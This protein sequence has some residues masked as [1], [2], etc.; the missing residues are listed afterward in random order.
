V[1]LKKHPSIAALEHQGVDPLHR[2]AALAP[3]LT[4]VKTSTVDQK[5][6]N[7]TQ[8]M[9][10][11]MAN[12]ERTIAMSQLTRLLLEVVILILQMAVI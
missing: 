1:V 10:V 11:L 6:T 5:Q 9:D 2:L 12:M 7:P 4:V 3:W 8:S